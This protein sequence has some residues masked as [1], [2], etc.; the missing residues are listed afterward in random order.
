VE[1]RRLAR[2]L[3][4][5]IALAAR[6]AKADADDVSLERPV[7]VVTAAPPLDAERLAAALRAYLDEFRVEVRTAPAAPGADLRDE[8]ATTAGIGAAAR[9]WAVVRIADGAPG[10][11]EIELVDRVTSKALVTAV[12]RPRR[13]EDLYR[14]VAL[15]VQSLLRVTLAEPSPSVSRSPALTHL[16]RA[17]EGARVA[18]RHFSLETSFAFVGFPNG[19]LTQQGLGV[20]LARR[21]GKRFELAAGTQALSAIDAQAGAVNASVSRVPLLVAARLVARGARWEAD[22]GILAEAALVSIDTSSPTLAVRSG[23]AVAPALGGQAGGRLRLGDRTWLCVRAAALGVIVGQHFTA[24]GQP[25]LSLSGLEA[26][27]E[28][29]VGMDLW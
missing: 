15:K 6:S 12:P 11:A 19:G 17:E 29:G 7:L 16:A 1:A 9:A 4:A 2:L 25:L 10:T 21:L 5:L 24:Q 28:A 23:W 18:E 20:F 8:L 26:A 27:V 3:I 13:D 14:S 22:A